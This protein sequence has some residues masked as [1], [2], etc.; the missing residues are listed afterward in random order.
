MNLIKKKKVNFLSSWKYGGDTIYFLYKENIIGLD[1]KMAHSSISTALKLLMLL[2]RLFWILACI[3][4]D[5]KPLKWLAVELS[6]LLKPL[7]LC[8]LHCNKTRKIGW[9]CCE[10]KLTYSC[11]LVDLLQSP[12]N[13]NSF[14]YILQLGSSISSPSPYPWHRIA[15]NNCARM[16]SSDKA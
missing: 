9:K 14:I 6:W 15:S 2:S 3:V 13:I 16:N 1:V 11:H 10:K 12:K 4:R 5:L 8:K 7:K